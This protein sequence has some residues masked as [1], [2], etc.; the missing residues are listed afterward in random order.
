MREDG[1]EAL[2]SQGESPA[3]RSAGA[4][5]TLFPSLSAE[6]VEPSEPAKPSE[7]AKPSQP[8]QPVK[9]S[10]PIK[11]SNSLEPS[12]PF[13]PSDPSKH[14]Q[15]L[16]PSNSLEPSNPPKPTKPLEPSNSSKPSK[17]A[18]PSEPSQSFLPTAFSQGAPAS[19]VVPTDSSMKSSPPSFVLPTS[20]A[21]QTPQTPQSKQT[22]QTPQSIQTPQ[23]PQSIQTPQ[24]PQASSKPVDPLAP[25]FP[26]VKTPVSTSGMLE[27]TIS[28][29]DLLQL[30]EIEEQTAAESKAVLSSE[31]D[32]IFA[33]VENEAAEEGNGAEGG[34]KVVESSLR[35][36]QFRLSQEVSGNWSEFSQLNASIL[37][38]VAPKG[39]NQTLSLDDMEDLMS[40]DMKHFL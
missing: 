21:P 5:G 25:G 19:H 40:E 33:S 34:G 30:L 9:R 6:P 12:R 24:T 28:D 38:S 1:A 36:E 22:S 18:R 37:Q 10:Q 23:T 2:F 27:S 11:P 39:I 13:E 15:P 7:Q 32:Q 31:V 3:K 14:S 35:E 26:V 17:P 4:A 29:E 8:S 20:K 16:K